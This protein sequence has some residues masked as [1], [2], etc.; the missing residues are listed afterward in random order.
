MAWSTY[1]AAASSALFAIC[2][3]IEV[4]GIAIRHHHKLNPSPLDLV[5]QREKDET[6]RYLPIYYLGT[7]VLVDYLIILSDILNRIKALFQLP[8][9]L[10]KS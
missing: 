1:T 10:L 8:I 2:F 9:F 5:I 7:Y 4:F 6:S 3:I